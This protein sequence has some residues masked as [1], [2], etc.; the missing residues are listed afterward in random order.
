MEL[1]YCF[2]ETL[3]Y[4]LDNVL[5]WEKQEYVLRRSVEH[6]SDLEKTLRDGTHLYIT[7]MPCLYLGH[8]YILFLIC[9][10]L[11]LK[12][13]EACLGKENI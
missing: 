10:G 12:I 9:L 7:K 2:S 3:R 5:Y 8:I 4:T 1:T 6:I 11:L 13:S